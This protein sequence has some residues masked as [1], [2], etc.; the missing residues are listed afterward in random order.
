MAGQLK[1]NPKAVESAI[2]TLAKTQ[3]ERT[4]QIGSEAIA[5]MN[6]EIVAAVSK[7]SQL[8]FDMSAYSNVQTL[9]QLSSA[10]KDRPITGGEAVLI[11]SISKG[12]SSAD[13]ASQF[14]PKE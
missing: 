13:K 14:K 8:G 1:D 2:A 10:M 11:E 4:A 9:E 6:K 3:S 12:L 5:A 7:A